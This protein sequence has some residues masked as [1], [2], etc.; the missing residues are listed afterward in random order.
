MAKELT[1]STYLLFVPPSASVKSQ[2]IELWDQRLDHIND[3]VIRA[4]SRN[5]LVDGLEVILKKETIIIL[6]T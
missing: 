4:M 3:N 6:V 2:S 5:N 1:I